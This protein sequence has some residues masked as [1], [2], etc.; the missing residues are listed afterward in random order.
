MWVLSRRLPGESPRRGFDRGILGACEGR[1]HGSGVGFDDIRTTKTTEDLED[2]G[3]KNKGMSKWLLS[4]ISVT[5]GTDR[6]V[7]TIERFKG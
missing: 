3:G 4:I 5:L 2:D 1:R 7:L 6:P